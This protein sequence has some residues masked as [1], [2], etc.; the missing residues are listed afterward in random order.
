M[1]HLSIQITCHDVLDLL[2]CDDVL[3]LDVWKL[4]PVTQNVVIDPI[5]LSVDAI[6]SW[7]NLTRDVALLT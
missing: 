4:D 6:S 1:I 5:D 3:R 7:F 2:S